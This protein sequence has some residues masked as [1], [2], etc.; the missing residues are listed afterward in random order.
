M[1]AASQLP[2]LSRS[3]VNTHIRRKKAG[4]EPVARGRRLLI[5]KEDQLR[6]C[7]AL[8]RA[9]GDLEPF[10]CAETQG[11]LHE[12]I[13]DTYMQGLFKDGTASRQCAHCFR[14]RNRKAT[15]GAMDT[16]FPQTMTHLRAEW[17]T[18]ANLKGCFD[19]SMKALVDSVNRTAVVNPEWDAATTEEQDQGAVDRTLTRLPGCVGTLD[20]MP[21]T[22]N[23]STGQK[24]HSDK[25]FG[26]HL[27]D[28]ADLALEAGMMAEWAVQLREEQHQLGKVEGDSSKKTGFRGKKRVRCRSTKHDKVGGHVG[29][30][31]SGEWRSMHAHGHCTFGKAGDAFVVATRNGGMNVQIFAECLEKCVF[32]CHP[33]MSPTGQCVCFLGWR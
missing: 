20:E 27:V 22:L 7:A 1:Q 14:M 8:A 3:L 23:V 12:L 16:Q 21:L 10:S 24:P 5:P 26:G 19:V 4:L 15:G 6:V 18:C 2:N 25:K 13:D 31:V 11:M 9:S 28:I 33:L 30:G 17:A 29:H 32:P